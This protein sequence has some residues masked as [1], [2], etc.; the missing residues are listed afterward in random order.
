VTLGAGNA[1]AAGIIGGTNQLKNGL[2]DL[3]TIALNR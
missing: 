1:E 2:L 3:T